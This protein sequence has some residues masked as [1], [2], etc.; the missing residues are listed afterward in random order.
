MANT[1]SRLSA[2]GSLTI[3]GSFDEVSGTYVSSGLLGS[4]DANRSYYPEIDASTWYDI[5][6]NNNIKIFNNNSTPALFSP[7]SNSA[8][9]TFSTTNGS[10]VAL[11]SYGQIAIPQLATAANVTIEGVLNLRQITGMIAGFGFYD[12]WTAGGTLGFNTFSSDVYGISAATV[13]SLNLLNRNVH[14]VFVMPTSNLPGAYQIW[15][16]GVQQSLSLVLGTGT[17]TTRAY[18]SYDG[19]YKFQL[20]GSY[21]G[22]PINGTLPSTGTYYGN[23]SWSSFRMYNRVLTP[24][25]IRQNYN[26]A[27]AR[28]RLGSTV[29]PIVTATRSNNTTQTIIQTIS[30]EFDEVTY[31]PNNSGPTKNMFSNSED[32]TQQFAWIIPNAT[33]TKN[34]ALAPN[35]TQT[36]SLFSALGQY[37]IIYY[38]HPSRT[39]YNGL[40][41]GEQGKYYTQSL[42]VKY[43]NQQY[44]V[45]VCEN[46]VGTGNTV[47]FDLINGTVTGPSYQ[48]VAAKIER[49]DNGWWRISVNI[50]IP[51]ATNT[52]SR[53]YPKW[54]PQ[55]RLGRYDGTNYTGS[56]ML[57]WGMQLE[58]GNT[59]STYVATG[60]PKNVLTFTND[61]AQNNN[62]YVENCN[63]SNSAALD[64]NGNY[65]GQLLSSTITGGTNT[66]FVQE[67]L[68]TLPINTDYTY[69]VYL[70]QGTSPTTYLN[71]YNASPF[72]ELVAIV[73]WP[74]VPGNTP[75]VSYSGGATRLNAIVTRAANGWW[76]FS[77]SMNNGTSSSL[78]W[79]IYT[80][81]NSTTNVAGYNVYI[82]G[83]QLEFGLT[84]TTYIENGGTFTNILP[85]AN[86]NM[87]MKTTNTGN[88]FIKGTYDEY[89]KMSPITEGLIFNVDPGYE[90]SYVGTGAAM[91]DTTSNKYKVDLL[92]NSTPK[93]S[94]DFGG[95]LKFTSTFR[96]NEYANTNFPART[97]TP[98]SN[99]TMSAWIKFNRSNSGLAE[100]QFYN[101][102][103]FALVS[104][105]ANTGY[106]YGS[107]GTILGTTYYG[108]YGL[109]WYSQIRTSGEKQ[110]LI[111]FQNRVTPYAEASAAQVYTMNDSLIFFNWTHIVGVLNN[112]GN[113][114]GFYVNGV[115]AS[116]TTASQIAS[117]SFPYSYPTVRI[118]AD[119][120]AGGSGI[121]RNFDGDTGPMSIWNRALSASEIQQMY[122]SQRS[123]FG[124]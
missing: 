52:D 35:N 101:P 72:S 46:W 25:E 82:W 59:A 9:I 4:W 26:I 38:V 84:P 22:T 79:R 83:P 30:G 43:V 36:A 51:F 123:R 37:P 94:S 1:A 74:T 50:L 93:Y 58:E 99:Y 47:E 105:Q 34:Y 108:D 121:G 23:V 48:A 100:F 8:N 96:D 12:I 60:F 15:I 40:F 21:I 2:N 106:A 42:F 55:W 64:P 17:A 113:F 97:I 70:K 89:S 13:T 118:C 78:V 69:S 61:F 109:F 86:T 87:V 95:I 73:T 115:L 63:V 53:G 5:A 117:G 41:F 20:N 19:T 65:K 76:R 44:C 120:V 88:T 31:N 56:Q 29:N 49:Y 62:W 27:S 71:F 77:L 10:S 66:G 90:G 7:S 116:S 32:F 28:Y 110:L 92:G 81:T 68:Y 54:N 111:G 107:S 16:N 112:A 39:S 124:V 6:G 119:N 91:Y 3:S 57:V 98:T 80:T 122:S 18:N 11:G 33:V 103:T 75:T 14:Y 85:L 114:A 24:D 45:F 102:V 67:T 104:P